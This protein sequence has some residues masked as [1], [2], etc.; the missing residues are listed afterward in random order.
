MVRHI[1]RRLSTALNVEIEYRRSRI[2]NACPKEHSRHSEN[3]LATD[4]Q[5]PAKPLIRQSLVT[6]QEG[7]N[8]PGSRSLTVPSNLYISLHR[9]TTHWVGFHRRTYR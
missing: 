7:S 1:G 3:E 2:S 4:R 6:I 9:A 8:H 5:T